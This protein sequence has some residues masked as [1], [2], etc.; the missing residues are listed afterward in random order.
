[1]HDNPDRI[2]RKYG[3]KDGDK[4]EFIDSNGSILL[5]PLKSLEELRGADL[6]RRKLVIQGI[7]ELERDAQG[8]TSWQ[9]AQLL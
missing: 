5:V 1:M 9:V 6:K 7:K 4:V 2:R 3:I 8:R